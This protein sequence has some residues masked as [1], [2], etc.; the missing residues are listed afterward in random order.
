MVSPRLHHVTTR[1]VSSSTLNSRRGE[2]E[3]EIFAWGQSFSGKN[4]I[5]VELEHDKKGL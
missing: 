2:F 1:R 5:F 4:D 3:F